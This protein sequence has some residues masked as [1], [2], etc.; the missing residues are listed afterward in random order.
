MRQYIKIKNLKKQLKEL[1]LKQKEAFDYAF[2][3]ISEEKEFL[4]FLEPFKIEV[5]K[6]KKEIE[7]NDKKEK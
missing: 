3:N 4:E 7:N 5:E 6:I 2:N 1:E